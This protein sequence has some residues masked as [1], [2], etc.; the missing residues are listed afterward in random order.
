MYLNVY[1]PQTSFGSG[2]RLPVVLYI[3]GGAFTFGSGS[4][5]FMNPYMY[6]RH[7]VILVSINYRLNLL[8]F[9]ALSNLPYTNFGLLD[10]RA[11]MEW[12]QQNI[13]A[14]GG[15]PTRVT[16]IGDSAGAISIVH[17]LT[18]PLHIKTPLFHRAIIIS[19]GLFAGPDLTLEK[20]HRQYLKISTSI[21]CPGDANQ[22][23]KCLLSLPV[24]SVRVVT[25]RFPTP[26]ISTYAMA[27]RETGFPINDRTFFPDLFESLASGQYD[28][29]TPV[30]VGS[31]LDE[32]TMFAAAAF[33]IVYPDEKLFSSIVHK[34][35]TDKADAVMERYGPSKTGSVRKSMNELTSHLFT[36][37]GTC[38]IARLMSSHSTAPIYRYGNFHLFRNP[39]NPNMGVFHT[40]AHAVFLRPNTPG[41]IFPVSY[42]EHELLMSDHFGQLL[43]Q[44]VYGKSFLPEEWPAYNSPSHLE[45]HIGPNNSSKLS[46]GTGFQSDDCDFWIQLYP[47]HGLDL[48]MYAGDLYEEEAWYAWI[49]NTGFWVLAR[50][51]R[52]LKTGFLLVAV[53]I[54]LVILYRFSPLRKKATITATGTAKKLKKE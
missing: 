37:H 20:A 54:F 42:D 52:L 51:I 17:H 46:I 4:S 7:D 24:T 50:N 41:L 40:A 29:K 27:L 16:A 31:D 53:A 9:I 12:I 23:L 33:P 11:A 25:G 30:I 1:A 36:S 6:T 47:P 45:L 15:D 48:P 28:R 14:F 26:F 21:G 22:A 39:S 34:L 35:F 5:L 8:G 10:Q 19:A 18:S 38:Q 2:S 32:G 49:A 43:M 44:F 3:H 13:E